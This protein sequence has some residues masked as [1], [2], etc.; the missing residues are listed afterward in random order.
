MSLAVGLT[1]KRSVHPNLNDDQVDNIIK[2]LTEVDSNA[3]LKVA[4]GII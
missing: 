4:N 2:I 3:A 1:I